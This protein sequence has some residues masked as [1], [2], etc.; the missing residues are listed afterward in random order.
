[1]HLEEMSRNESPMFG[2]ELFTVTRDLINLDFI[3]KKIHQIPLSEKVDYEK[4]VPIIHRI[5]H[6]CDDFRIPL[7]RLINFYRDLEETKGNLGEALTSK[8]SIEFLTLCTPES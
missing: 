4:Y 5:S 2:L 6:G 7:G 1:M 3:Y 8:E